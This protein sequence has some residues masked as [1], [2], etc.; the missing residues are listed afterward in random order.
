MAVLGVRELAP[1]FPAGRA[2]VYL[3]LA[4][5]IV[6]YILKRP[7]WKKSS[8]KPPHSKKKATKNYRKMRLR[9]GAADAHRVEGAVDERKGD[10]EESRREKVSEVCTLRGRHLDGEL[11]GEQAE[12]RG[13][14]DHRIERD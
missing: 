12:E 14:L 2:Y 1:A 7:D 5:I 4:I 10:G 9:G 11:D 13:E 6:S 3:L 8:G